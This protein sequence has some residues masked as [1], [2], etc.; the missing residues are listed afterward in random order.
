MATGYLPEELRQGRAWLLSL[1]LVCWDFHSIVRSLNDT[2]TLSFNGVYHKYDQLLPHLTGDISVVAH[3]LTTLTIRH[4]EQW[5]EMSIM[6]TFGNAEMK[7]WMR[8]ATRSLSTAN[9]TLNKCSLQMLE[10]ADIDNL[11]TLGIEVCSLPSGQNDDVPQVLQALLDA[12]P[13]IHT[14]N[15]TTRNNDFDSPVIYKR[16]MKVLAVLGT[17]VRRLSIK[18][19][20]TM[21]EE[22]NVN[23]DDF[24]NDLASS[25]PSLEHLTLRTK[26]GVDPTMSPRIESP[27]FYN[28][29]EGYLKM[30]NTLKS[31]EYNEEMPV[32]AERL[33]ATI[34]QCPNIVDTKFVDGL[35]LQ[36]LV[37]F[38]R[39]LDRLMVCIDLDITEVATE[40]LEK[41]YPFLNNA[42]RLYLIVRDLEPPIVPIINEVIRR[43]QNKQLWI[44]IV[45]ELLD[46]SDAEV[47]DPIAPVVESNQNLSFFRFE[48]EC[49][50]AEKGD[51]AA[52]RNVIEQ[53][54]TIINKS[55]ALTIET[56]YVPGW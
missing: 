18:D 54:P 5:P 13:N 20:G 56:E 26:H 7:A 33:V 55:T 32:E 12:N 50:R 27:H 3:E 38:S 45:P 48:V 43:S 46:F 8:G 14:L 39:R 30:Q 16:L 47:F 21:F 24:F 15:I 37:P 31:L 23:C 41:V 2:L 29:F 22:I 49:S 6:E 36:Y 34:L 19:C 25:A 28:L 17:G 51:L 35:P 44:R 10:G 1:D 9:I 4:T 52:L 11:E 53:H 42:D 40:V